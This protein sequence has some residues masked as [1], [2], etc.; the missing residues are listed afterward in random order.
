MGGIDGASRGNLAGGITDD[1]AE[2]DDE[3]VIACS[4]TGALST[5]SGPNDV[6]GAM[7]TVG[8]LLIDPGVIGVSIH[9]A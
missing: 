6:G 3:R 9:A 1:V 2:G 5:I 8:E 7:A 4:D